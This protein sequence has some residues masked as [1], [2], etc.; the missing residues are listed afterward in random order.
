MM[1]ALW[2]AVTAMFGD[3]RTPWRRPERHGFIDD[4]QSTVWRIDQ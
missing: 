2:S 3:V 1:Y 4:R